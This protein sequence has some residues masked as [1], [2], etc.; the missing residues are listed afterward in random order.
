MATGVL[1][2]AR[3]DCEVNES[4]QSI[5]F[6]ELGAE[7]TVVVSLDGKPLE[8]IALLSS[9]QP[10]PNANPSSLNYVPTQGWSIGTYSFQAKL[11][12]SEGVVETSTAA[13]L[14]VT[15]EAVAKAVSWAILGVIIGAILIVAAATV[16]VILRR[17][18]DMLRA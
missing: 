12:I 5:L 2:F 17:R 10:K 8:E 4:Y 14:K 6:S 9:S 15:A 7:L 13:A 11:S 18:R 1:L 16:I 3:I